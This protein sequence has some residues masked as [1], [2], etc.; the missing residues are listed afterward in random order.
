MIAYVFWHRR[1]AGVAVED[2]QAALEAFHISLLD[3]RLP[4][5]RR[6]MIFQTASLPWL[7]TED[8]LFEDWHLLDGSAVLDRLDE[9]AVSGERAEPHGRI[10]TLVDTGVAGLYRLRLGEP[11]IPPPRIAYWLSKPAGMS[12]QAFFDS[13]QPLCEDGAALWSRQMVLGPTPEFCLRSSGDLVLP[14][15]ALRSDLTPAL[16]RQAPSQP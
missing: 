8:V 14:Y 4:G 16:D 1:R 5:F 11:S 10:A 13:L 6:T 7:S 3:S 9:A 2:Y 15:A 12:Y